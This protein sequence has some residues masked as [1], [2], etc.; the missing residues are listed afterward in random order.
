M[1]SRLRAAARVTLNRPRVVGLF[2]LASVLV[3]P[4][5]YVAVVAVVGGATAGA[6]ATGGM[7]PSFALFDDFLSR[8]L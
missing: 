3:A 8:Q 6:T 4:F 5:C 2:L 1:P 7:P